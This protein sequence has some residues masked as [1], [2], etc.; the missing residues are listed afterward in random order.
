LQLATKVLPVA[1]DNWRGRQLQRL[2]MTSS[3]AQEMR[4]KQ[5]SLLEVYDSALSPL[6]LLLFIIGVMYLNGIIFI[7]IIIISII[8]VI[9]N[10][11]IFLTI[12]IITI[13]YCYFSV[14]I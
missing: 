6:L 12:I 8:I 5:K 10:G 14:V 3:L 1:F 11:I 9:L 7:T 13:I 2:L 4:D